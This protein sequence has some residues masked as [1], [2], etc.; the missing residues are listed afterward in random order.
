MRVCVYALNR[1]YLHV[2]RRFKRRI[3]C[4]DEVSVVD[5]GYLL[6]GRAL[7]LGAWLR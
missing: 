1:V 5:D 4:I 7:L 3:V 2:V 6:C